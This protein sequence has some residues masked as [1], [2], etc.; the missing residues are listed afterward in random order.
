[1]LHKTQKNKT[2]FFLLFLIIFHI[3][4]F[5]SLKD[6]SSSSS[7]KC[8]KGLFFY[9]IIDIVMQACERVFAEYAAG[10]FVLVR[11][12]FAIKAI[13][14]RRFFY[15]PRQESRIIF[16]DEKKCWNA[17][18]IKIEHCRGSWELWNDWQKYGGWFFSYNFVSIVL[19]KLN[20]RASDVNWERHA[21][22]INFNYT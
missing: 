7:A 18:C 15:S 14:K 4:Y 13:S 1:M 3:I 17:R 9:S 16:F 10:F 21:C 8:R 19:F 20:I 2:F 12:A 11:F 5:F 6:C 22:I